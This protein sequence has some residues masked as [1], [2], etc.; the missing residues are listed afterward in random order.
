[1]SSRIRGI[2]G[3]LF[4]WKFCRELSFREVFAG[5]WLSLR[6]ILQTTR[7]P[8]ELTVA[9]GEEFLIKTGLDRNR[10]FGGLCHWMNVPRLP[11]VTPCFLIKWHVLLHEME[12]ENS[13]NSSKVGGTMFWATSGCCCSSLFASCCCFP[14]ECCAGFY[15]PQRQLQRYAQITDCLCFQNISRL[16]W[17]RIHC[18]RSF[19]EEEKKTNAILE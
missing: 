5:D 16:S 2:K 7:E 1:M 13:L 14:M 19:W 4:P 8:E 18:H 6:R 15:I 3:F 12:G 17:G 9:A 10:N 11:S